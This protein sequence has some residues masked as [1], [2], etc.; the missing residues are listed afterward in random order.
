MNM[1]P[2]SNRIL[3]DHGFSDYNQKSIQIDQS[4]ERILDI[5]KEKVS[6]Y[7]GYPY[8]SFNEDLKDYTVCKMPNS[9][10]N[11]IDLQNLPT[12]KIVK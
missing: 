1:L 9:K 8:I 7:V 12:N 2:K 5:I 11:L 6:Y 3:I 4:S 10:K